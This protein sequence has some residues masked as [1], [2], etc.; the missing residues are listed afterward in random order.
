ME[1]PGEPVTRMTD[2]E[3]KEFLAQNVDDEVGDEHGV[4]FALTEKER[5]DCVAS[6]VAHT[7]AAAAKEA[8]DTDEVDDGGGFLSGLGAVTAMADLAEGEGEQA[9]P[10]PAGA[11][12]QLRSC[13]LYTSPSPRD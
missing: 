9:Q 13:L 4:T 12:E 7:A 11:E 8:A 3:V 1:Y 6:I 5:H 10:T 2:E